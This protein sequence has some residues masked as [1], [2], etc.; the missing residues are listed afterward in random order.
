MANII[1]FIGSIA[2]GKSSLIEALSK[3][4][5]SLNYCRE[6]VKIWSGEEDYLVSKRRDFLSAG[7]AGGQ[8]DFIRLQQV[9]SLCQFRELLPLVNGS[10]DHQP[11]VAERDLFSSVIFTRAARAQGLLSADIDV[12]LVELTARTLL[13]SNKALLQP[14]LLVYL[15]CD[16]DTSLHRVRERARPCEQVVTKE[17]LQCLLDEHDRWKADNFAP[18]C[19]KEIVLLCSN[20]ATPD[21]LLSSVQPLIRQARYSSLFQLRVCHH[22]FVIQSCHLKL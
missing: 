10:A 14:E 9:A 12:D 19:P 11:F 7:V 3:V 4:Y 13:C 6:S 21:Q 16:A 8:L 15:Y 2:V 20:D 5:P 18:L 22:P 1:Y 17:Y